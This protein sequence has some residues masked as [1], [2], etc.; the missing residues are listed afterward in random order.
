VANVFANIEITTVNPLS[1]SHHG[2]AAR[3]DGSKPLPTMIRGISEG[4]EPL[5]TVFWPAAALRGALRH[6]AA[7]ADMR[8]AGNLTLQDAYLLALGQDLAREESEARDKMEAKKTGKKTEAKPQDIMATVADREA[9]HAVL[10]LF[11]TWKMPSRLQV[12]NLL[13]SVNVRADKFAFI[14]RDLDTDVEMFDALPEADR[15]AFYGRQKRQSDAS[16][17]GDQ[18][19]VAEKAIK[20]AKKAKNDALLEELEAKLAELQALK[21]ATKGDDQSGNTKHLLEVEAIPAGVVLTGKLVVQRAKSRDLD[22]L[23]DGLDAISRKPVFGAHMARGFGEIEGK[24]TFTNDDGE[25][26]CLVRFGGYA[27]AAVEWTEAGSEMRET[28]A[29]A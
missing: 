6:G 5:R 10:D 15:D 24:A 20:A 2:T 23:I 8:A 3:A 11:G 27:K 17:V 22:L 13:P 21:E 7:L 18:I 9:A 28:Q 26:L 1:F 25:V 29:L 19:D 12:A 4:G 14:R 16:K